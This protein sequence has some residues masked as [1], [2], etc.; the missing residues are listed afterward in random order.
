[1]LATLVAHKQIERSAQV[2]PHSGRRSNWKWADPKERP[3]R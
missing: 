2:Y 1:L 3:E